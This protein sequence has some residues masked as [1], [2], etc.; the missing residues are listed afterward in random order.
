MA[1]YKRWTGGIFHYILNVILPLFCSVSLRY[2]PNRASWK[3][4]KHLKNFVSIFYDFLKLSLH[5]NIPFALN[6]FWKYFL[7]NPECIQHGMNTCIPFQYLSIWSISRPL[8]Q[9][10]FFFEP[11][12]LYKLCSRRQPTV[13]P[14]YQIIGL[15][16]HRWELLHWYGLKWL[17]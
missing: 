15:P 10:I 14:P 3:R 5:N 9:Q 4:V 1:V 13:N 7:F 17:I 12:S 11:C 6:N 2:I 8:F 16:H